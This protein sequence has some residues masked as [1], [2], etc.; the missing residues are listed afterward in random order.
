VVDIVVF[1]DRVF[2]LVEAFM[3]GVILVGILELDNRNVEL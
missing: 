1:D 2:K 3:P